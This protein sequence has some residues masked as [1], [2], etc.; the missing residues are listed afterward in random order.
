MATGYN[1]LT[2]GPNVREGGHG[3]LPPRL[4]NGI[5][6]GPPSGDFMRRSLVVIAVT[7]TLTL[8][9]SRA[10]A[11]QPVGDTAYTRTE[12][13][14]P[15]RDSV[16]LFTVIVA[17]K[18]AATPLPILM[19]RTPYSAA[20]A[21][22][23]AARNA[24]VLGLGG[25]ILV[26]QDIRRRDSSEGTFDMNPA[27]HSGHAGTHE[28]TDT[29]DTID[30]LVK[31]VPNNNGKVGVFGISYPGWLTAVTGI[32]AHRA[33][34]A[35]SP[36][37]PMG[38]AWMGDDFF[39]QG[40]FRL[41]YGLEYAWEMEAS[42]DLSVT[43][44]PGRYDTFE[45]YLS[46]PTLGALARAVGADRWPTWRRFAGHPAYDSVWQARSLPPH[47]PHQNHPT[48]LVG[49]W[50]D[51]EDEY[52]PLATDTVLEHSDTAGLHHPVMGPGVHGQGVA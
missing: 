12:V 1:L 13:K 17:P 47:L 41:T 32:G 9:S 38:D 34:K 19:E 10:C 42:S 44:S 45:W 8:P 15:M 7:L 50:W 48:L 11:Q 2:R 46:F 43:P 5:L 25:Y 40:A 14:I 39:H 52:G 21:A 31:N 23:G 18:S 26:F 28:S 33:L 49:G 6:P 20:G 51:Q 22:G 24:P 36:Q 4:T 29:Y 16:R 27:P 30:W 35:I 3:R 37:A